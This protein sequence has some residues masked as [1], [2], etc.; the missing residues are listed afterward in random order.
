MRQKHIV[1]LLPVLL[2]IT[3]LFAQP[4][5]MS[6]P[7]DLRPDAGPFVHTLTRGGSPDTLPIGPGQPFFDDFSSGT[8]LPDSLRWFYPSTYA[9]VPVLTRNAAV[10]PPTRGVATFDG[11]NRAGRP[12]DVGNVSAGINDRLYSHYIDLSPFSAGDQVRLT[13]FL[14]PQGRGD[15]PETADSFYVYLR[16]TSPAPNEF[17]KAL[18]V[19]GSSLRSFRQYVI[20]ITDPQYFH[21]GFQLLF[22]NKGSRNGR[23]DLWHLDYVQLG[24]NRSASDTT[25]SDR[26]PVQIASPPLAPFTA[27]PFR[28][29]REG[30]MQ[31]FDVSVSN[32][33]GQNTVATV[34]AV[35]ADPVGQTPFSGNTSRQTSESFAPRATEAVSLSSFTDQTFPQAGVYQLQVS[36]PGNNDIHPE[37]DFFDETYRIDSLMGYDDGEADAGFG[38]NQSLGFG[39]RYEL[40]APDTISAVWICFT[41]NVIYNPVSTL[42]RYMDDHPFRIAV[43]NVQHP[44]SLIL[45]QSSGARVKYGEGANTFVRYPLSKPLA[46]PRTF[47][48]G[49]QQTDN[50]PLGI[51][52]D[53]TYNRDSYTYWDS[54]GVMTNARLGGALMIRP[55]FYTYRPATAGNDDFYSGKSAVNVYPNPLTGSELYVNCET[56]KGEWEIRLFDLSGKE[57]LVGE[58]AGAFQQTYIMNVPERIPNGLYLLKLRAGGQTYVQRVSVLR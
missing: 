47:W 43:W 37:N 5:L 55:E 50:L 8:L 46:V 38:L 32:L 36:L 29:N 23:L 1:L 10:N 19:G 20:S 13:F 56:C 15:R 53:L 35:I 14:Q 44:D 48:V 57:Y 17:R 22:L 54:V 28:I 16:S 58:P 27:V 49:V 34:K 30:Y 11:L 25:Y 9:D 7:E 6:D 26:S 51:G 31:P 24:V 4:V 45:Q 42:T 40:P 33:W 12:Y 52:Y 21:A 18:A 39:M 41:P 2:G 3:G